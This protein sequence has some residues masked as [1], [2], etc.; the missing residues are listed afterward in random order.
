MFSS[1]FRAS[2]DRSPYSDFWF[3]PVAASSN[4]NMRITA[5]SALYLSTVFRCV[6]YK[7]GQQ[8]LL[9]FVLYKERS[10]GSKLKI[11]NHPLYRLFT[12]NPNRY[13]NRFQ[14]REMLNAHIELRG[15]AYNQIIN[16]GNGIITELMPLHPDR[17]KM[18]LLDNGSYRYRYTDRNGVQ[19]VLTRGEVW[20]IRGLSTDGLMGL[21]TIELARSS[22]GSALSAQEYGSRFWT[23]DAKPTG[24]W[25]ETVGNFKDKD[26]AKDFRDSV[27]A[28]Q[29]GTNKHKIMVLQ[30]G[31]KYHEV[32]LTNQDA[33]FLETR[34]FNVSEI[35]R[36]FGVPPHK[37]MDLEKA[38]FSNIEQQSLEA[39][40]DCLIPLSARWEAAIDADLLFDDEELKVE[41]DYTKL[42]RGD[43]QA[44]GR[45]YH[46][47]IL[48]G[49]MTRNEARIAE[50]MEPIDGLDEPL[51]PLNM[52]S[53]SN[54]D[55]NSSD[56]SN[57]SNNQN[58]RAN[59]LA[60]A[61]AERVAR[62]ETEMVK[63]AFKNN[64]A[65]TALASVFAQHA[66]F[67]AAA[68]NIS[69]ESANAYCQDQINAL[70]D[71]TDSDDYFEIARCKLERLALKGTL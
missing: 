50:N 60:Q 11:T 31:M 48:D 16:D 3:S 61:A 20:H 17:I 21:S 15:N 59:A 64:D 55:L 45:Y 19:Q 34:K 37:V 14:W 41:F 35:A 47:G 32:G 69:T 49:W 51:T 28:A 23:N 29:S 42:L 22:M 5:D 1:F 70:Q 4:G 13:Q 38:T 58:A 18:E 10:D 2:A 46:A 27:Q 62:K 57:G 7:A 39:I 12:K 9:P 36:W 30:G 25:I 8:A 56:N 44:R 40:Q 63:N 65:A 26:A 67:V 43:S 24:G 66:G 6:S 68:L 71:S 54:P 52:A 53:D 33:Q